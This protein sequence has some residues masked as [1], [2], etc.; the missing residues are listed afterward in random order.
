LRE[1]A[2]KI[3]NR[4]VR[5]ITGLP[6]ADTQCGFKAFRLERA[7]VIFEQQR[8]EGFGFDPEI[9]FL[10]RR[11]GLQVKEVSVRWR[12]DAASKVNVISDSLRMLFDLVAVRWNVVVGRYP[13][14]ECGK[15]VSALARNQ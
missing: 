15:R 5:S 3:F 9:L 6:F 11:H 10:A 2:G 12:N 1:L 8:I 4:I 14:K 13:R 7:R